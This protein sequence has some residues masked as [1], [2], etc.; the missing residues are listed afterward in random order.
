MF[1]THAQS[2]VCFIMSFDK[3]LKVLPSQ[4]HI[5]IRVYGHCCSGDEHKGD[6]DLVGSHGMSLVY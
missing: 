4:N 6:V 3:I 5:H 1:A 2:K